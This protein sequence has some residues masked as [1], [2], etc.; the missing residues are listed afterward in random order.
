MSKW[1]DGGMLGN[2]TVV[3]LSKEKWEGVREDFSL[4]GGGVR[5]QIF[6]DLS[7]PSALYL[8]IG[9]KSR[10]PNLLSPLRFLPIA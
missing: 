7:F 8:V 10:P 1:V 9:S 6:R 5:L 2:S 4:K 3:E